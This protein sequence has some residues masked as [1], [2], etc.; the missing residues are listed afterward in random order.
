MLAYLLSMTWEQAFSSQITSNVSNAIIA[1]CLKSVHYNMHY[2]KFISSHHASGNFRTMPE[3]LIEIPDA[4]IF[5][6]LSVKYGVMVANQIFPV[7]I[8]FGEHLS[9]QSTKTVMQTCLYSIAISFSELDLG[10]P[11]YNFVLASLKQQIITYVQGVQTDE[12]FRQTVTI[13]DMIGKLANMMSSNS[14]TIFI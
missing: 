2:I 7:F 6:Y 5:N 9:K 10:N 11:S 8:S 3:G 1:V 14:F 13:C 4:V 12:I